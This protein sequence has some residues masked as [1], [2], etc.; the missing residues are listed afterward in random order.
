[1]KECLDVFCNLSGQQVSFNRSRIFCSNNI[2]ERD[3][4]SIANI[5]GSPLTKNLGKYLGVPLIHSRVNAHTYVDVVEKVQQILV[6]WKSK[7]MS[8]AGRLP[9]TKLF[10]QLSWYTLCSL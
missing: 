3:A 9:L 7:S 6:A 10:L 2:K 1:M 8:L 4:K 5:C